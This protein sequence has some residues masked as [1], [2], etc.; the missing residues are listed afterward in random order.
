MGGGA[1]VV[2]RLA[3]LAVLVWLGRWALRRLAALSA[4]GAEPGPAPL[5]SPRA[6]GRGPAEG[7]PSN[8]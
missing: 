4:A 3:G 2:R 5:D 6:P 8:E 1:V 7:A